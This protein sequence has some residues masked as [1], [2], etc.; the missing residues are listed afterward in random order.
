LARRKAFAVAGGLLVTV[1]LAAGCGDDGSPRDA[2]PA[3]GSPAASPATASLLAAVRSDEGASFDALYVGVVGATDAF[4]AVGVRGDEVV[5]YLCD[6]DDVGKWLVG[7]AD[8]ASLTAGAGPDI[9]LDAR[10]VSGHLQGEVAGAAGSEGSF[11]LAPADAD[12]AIIGAG[13]DPSPVTAGLVIFDGRVRG[14]ASFR[15]PKGDTS[16]G[17][18][19]TTTFE[20]GDESD[21]DTPG[22]DGTDDSG[23]DSTSDSA[24]DP[25]LCDALVAARDELLGEIEAIRRSLSTKVEAFT[26]RRFRDSGGSD[27]S[28]S[29]DQAGGS[30]GGGR[31]RLIDVV[32]TQALDLLVGAVNDQFQQTFDRAGCQ[33]SEAS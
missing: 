20:D 18:K 26:G 4:L 22:K 9:R 23:S 31:D 11:D 28:D 27:A 12:D 24:A 15:G 1:L 19:S 29:A 5:A 33:G 6:G 17:T 25:A 30:E 3:G 32:V 2:A 10:V 14:M 8:G 13:G 7:S 21:S 16:A